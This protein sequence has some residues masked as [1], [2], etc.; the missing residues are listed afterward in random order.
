MYVS[1]TAGGPALTGSPD[2][3]LP[4]EREEASSPRKAGGER[5]LGRT[6]R[7]SG[8]PPAA[9]D[10]ASNEET[11][12]RPFTRRVAC[13]FP[14]LKGSDRSPDHLAARSGPPRSTSAFGPP[15]TGKTSACPTDPTAP[16]AQLTPTPD[17]PLGSAGE[18]RSPVDPAVHPDGFTPRPFA[19]PCGTQASGDSG[20]AAFTGSASQSPPKVSGCSASASRSKVAASFC[21]S[22][23]R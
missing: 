10:R 20:R 15:T 22:A 16:R 18:T 11:R 4:A 21:S 7:L 9:K 23:T 14:W 3:T 17:D 5:T 2:R 12:Y 13:A 8:R 1:E 6:E 19:K